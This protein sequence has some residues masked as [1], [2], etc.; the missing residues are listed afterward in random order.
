MAD[1]LGS[2]VFALEW[3]VDLTCQHEPAHKGNPWN[4]C[5]DFIAKAV[6]VGVYGMQS[7]GTDAWRMVPVPA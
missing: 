4:E 7:V 3:V 6:R 1:A 2:L 5:A